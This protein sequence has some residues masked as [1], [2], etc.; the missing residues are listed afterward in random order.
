MNGEREYPGRSITWE[1]FTQGTLK[2]WMAVTMNS[3]REEFPPRPDGEY[4]HMAAA[5][6]MRTQVE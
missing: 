4:N 3:L 2:G 6:W 5:H 1:Y